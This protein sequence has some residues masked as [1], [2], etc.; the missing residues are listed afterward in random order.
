MQCHYCDRPADVEVESDG[1]IVGLCEGHLRAR[2]QELADEAGVA[3]LR[4]ELDF[5][6]P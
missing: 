3:A 1:V 4:E 6:E 2:V 5:E